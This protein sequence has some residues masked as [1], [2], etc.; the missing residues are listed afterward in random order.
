MLH[1]E[2][3]EFVNG[4]WDIPDVPTVSQLAQL[5]GCPIEPKNWYLLPYRKAGT[6]FIY[7]NAWPP[8]GATGFFAQVAPKW[9]GK[10]WR[11]VDPDDRLRLLAVLPPCSN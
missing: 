11:F 3:D 4:H 7:A 2:K 6:Y 9:D 5:L 8:N 10:G 1:D